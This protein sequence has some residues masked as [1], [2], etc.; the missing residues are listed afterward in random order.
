MTGY[1]SFCPKVELNASFQKFNGDDNNTDCTSSSDDSGDTFRESDPVELT[2]KAIKIRSK[3][4]FKVLT[5]ATI[6][7]IFLRLAVAFATPI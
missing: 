7:S 5:L 2:L 6:I 3:M 4:K 1:C